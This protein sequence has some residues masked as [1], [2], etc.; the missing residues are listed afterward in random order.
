MSTISVTR[1]IKTFSSLNGR[2]LLAFIGAVFGTLLA[3]MV[4]A[5]ST[6]P[7]AWPI[8]YAA[9]MFYRQGEWRSVPIPMNDEAAYQVFGRGE[10]LSPLTNAQAYQSFRKGE[11]S[12]PVWLTAQEASLFHRQGEWISVPIPVID[13]QA[14]FLSE[15]TLTHAGIGMATYL[16]SERILHPVRNLDQFTLY[17]RSEWFEK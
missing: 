11:V 14:Y 15:R 13:L 5:A 3:V 4:I 17:Q 1:K 8:D 6:S 2:Q 10:V 12:S 16:N 9:Y 7:A